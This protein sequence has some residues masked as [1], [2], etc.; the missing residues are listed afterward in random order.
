MVA[1]MVTL[2][3]HDKYKYMV[4]DMV[5]LDDHDKYGRKQKQELILLT[6]MRAIKVN[7][8]SVLC[9]TLIEAWQDGHCLQMIAHIACYLSVNLGECLIVQRISSYHSGA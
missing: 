2:D 8:D 6:G 3:D 4:A 9:T 5:T 1:D 7:P